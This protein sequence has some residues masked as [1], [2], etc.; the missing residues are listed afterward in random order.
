MGGSQQVQRLCPRRPKQLQGDAPGPDGNAPP[1]AIA[2]YA[3]PTRVRQQRP[4]GGLDGRHAR[5]PPRLPSGY[6]YGHAPPRSRAA[7]VRPR[8]P[9][10]RATQQ[11]HKL[12]RHAAPHGAPTTPV[13]PTL[14]ESSC[15]QPLKPPPP[16]RKSP[17][18]R[19]SRN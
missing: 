9:L 12:C 17:P 2:G 5:R 11:I 18:K 16:N 6:G 10:C 14:L 19:T 1:R 13:V 15:Q 8:T 3:A 4:R 7:A